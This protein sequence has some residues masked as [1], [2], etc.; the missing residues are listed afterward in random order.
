M[1]VHAHGFEAAQHTGCSVDIVHTP[2]AEP[3]AI[4]LLF[5]QN[6]IN[7]LAHPPIIA[8]VAVRGQHLQ[9]APGDIYRGRVEHGVVVGERHVLKDHAVIIFVEGSPTAVAALHGKDPVNGP[10]G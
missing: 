10:L 7:R 3:G 4:R 1:V 8:A 5:A 6:K 9:H 2:T